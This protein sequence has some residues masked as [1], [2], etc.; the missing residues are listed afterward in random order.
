MMFIFQI[1]YAI[2][3][4]RPY[5]SNYTANTIEHELN[6][7]KILVMLNVQIKRGRRIDVITTRVI[8]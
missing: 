7:T 4:T 5:R 6:K 1:I 8:P 3:S 2:L